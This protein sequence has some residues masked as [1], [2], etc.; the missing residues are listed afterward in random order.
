MLTQITESGSKSVAIP[1][2]SEEFFLAAERCF[3]STEK[4]RENFSVT[5][6]EVAVQRHK[7]PCVRITCLWEGVKNQDLLV[8]VAWCQ[9]P[10]G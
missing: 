6:G 2:A 7:Y 4:G 10:L 1:N 9:N 3:L 5:K 8:I